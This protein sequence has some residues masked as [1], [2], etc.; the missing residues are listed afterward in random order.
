PRNDRLAGEVIVRD[1]AAAAGTRPV[2]NHHPIAGLC[3]RVRPAGPPVSRHQITTAGMRAAVDQKQR[4]LSAPTPGGL[5]DV[6][7]SDRR[8][9]NAAGPANVAVAALRGGGRGCKRACGSG[10]L[11]HLSTRDVRFACGHGLSLFCRTAIYQTVK[12]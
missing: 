9:G 11:Y 10:P 12:R 1:M 7:I 8:I 6:E 2:R 5:D 3:E 4:R